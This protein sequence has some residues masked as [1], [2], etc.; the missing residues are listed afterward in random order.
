[1]MLQKGETGVVD[2]GI[3]SMLEWELESAGMMFTE[4]LGFV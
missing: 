3:I 2:V 1:M 4:F